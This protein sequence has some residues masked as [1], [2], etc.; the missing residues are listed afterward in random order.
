MEI[1]N[2]KFK[3]KIKKMSGKE[4]NECFKKYTDKNNLSKV[5]IIVENR[6]QDIST[7][8]FYKIIND[9]NFPLFE[10]L[11][12]YYGKDKYILIELINYLFKISERDE[13]L[14]L[15][16]SH[17]PII[18]LDT[19]YSVSSLNKLIEHNYDLSINNNKFIIDCV[20]QGKHENVKYLLK[21][22]GIDPSAQKNEAIIYAIESNDKKM[23]TILLKD[24]RVDPSDRNNVVFER[25]IKFNT[26]LYYTEMIKILSKDIRFRYNFPTI[27]EDDFNKKI[28]LNL[29]KD[30]I[31]IDK[32]FGLMVTDGIT[33]GV[34][35][36]VTDIAGLIFKLMKVKEKNNL[37]YV[38][39]CLDDLKFVELLN[40]DISDNEIIEVFKS[41][42]SIDMKINIDIL[43]RSIERDIIRIIKKIPRGFPYIKYII[44]YHRSMP[45]LIECIKTKNDDYNLL[46]KICL[47]RNEYKLFNYVLNKK[48]L[49]TD[50]Y[51]VEKQILREFAKEKEIRIFYDNNFIT[52]EEYELK[53]GNDIMNHK[54]L[55]KFSDI[56]RIDIERDD[57]QM[58]HYESLDEYYKSA[59]FISEISQLNNL[60]NKGMDKR[61]EEINDLIVSSPKQR[62]KVVG[63]LQ[64]APEKNEEYYIMK[65]YSFISNR[66]VDKR[67]P[68][69][70]LDENVR[71]LLTPNYGFLPTNSLFEKIEGYDD[72]YKY[73]GYKTVDGEKYIF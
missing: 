2:Q 37:R 4:L 6:K 70:I 35:G 59:A 19:N 46:T 20:I 27:R 54:D 12:V 8:I 45:K 60:S 67:L 50:Y 7:S 3:D 72:V 68:I 58:I 5:Q 47:E 62:F 63:F 44:K 71:Y 41:I 36:G 21:I 25:M 61:I 29:I 26:F 1:R 53:T 18:E 69:V 49:F 9:G 66:A 64:F 11:M 48:P 51:Y 34:T 30:R 32:K 40:S 13:F 24:P 23:V 31:E 42:K 33:G 15:I 16:L 14:D 57:E 10:F 38:F 22:D 56:H 65:G 43:F 55:L 52:A 39:S 73:I 28:F 17:K